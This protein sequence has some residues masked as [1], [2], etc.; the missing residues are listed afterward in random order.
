MWSVDSGQS[1]RAQ[2]CRWPITSPIGNVYMCY[3]PIVMLVSGLF[4]CLG[5]TI[6]M[7]HNN[8]ESCALVIS[9]VRTQSTTQTTLTREI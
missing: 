8:H 3:A 9:D 1:L 4:M 5:W 6:H 2:Q 7:F